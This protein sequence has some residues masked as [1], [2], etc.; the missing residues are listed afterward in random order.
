MLGEG[1]QPPLIP[2]VG[3]GGGRRARRPRASA[4]PLGNGRNVRRA[5]SQPSPRRRWLLVV[6]ALLALGGG[7]GWAYA[8]PTFRVANVAVV[9]AERVAAVA[10]IDASGLLNQSIFTLDHDRALRAI[11]ANPLI[12]GVSIAT[13]PP[14][15]VAIRI[16]E[17]Q[18]W[19]LWQIGASYYSVDEEGVVLGEAKATPERP[20][21]VDKAT[22]PLAVGD[23]V[24]ADAIRLVTRL[25]ELLPRALNTKGLAFEYA[26]DGGIVAVIDGGWRARF[27][28]ASD[29]DRKIA[30]WKAVLAEGAKQ[31]M[32]PRHVDLRFGDRPF[33]RY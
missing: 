8:S 20:L 6:A 24:D 3:A 32:T 4:V 31:N 14:N 11:A 19:G 13:V 7:I 10:V 1:T 25:R 21:I 16:V 5:R 33:F 30:V 15:S 29:I 28:D 18:S 17:R 27:G 2:G 23:R 22:T 12:K 26:R 9:G